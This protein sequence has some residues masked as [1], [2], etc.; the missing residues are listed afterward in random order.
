MS[1]CLHAGEYPT[2]LSLARAMP[3]TPA[4]YATL[5]FGM[6]THKYFVDAIEGI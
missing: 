2:A 3:L 4:T 5:L 6:H 1:I